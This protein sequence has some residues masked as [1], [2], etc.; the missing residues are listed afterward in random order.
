M[1]AGKIKL[2]NEKPVSVSRSAMVRT[3]THKLIIRPQDQSEL[4]NNDSD[5]Q[6]RNNL[7]G[8]PSVAFIQVELQSRLLGNPCAGV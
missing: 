2:Q 4:Y 8:D 5:P 6:E 3:K 1:Y 7:Y